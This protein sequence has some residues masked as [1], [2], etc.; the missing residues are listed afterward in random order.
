MAFVTRPIAFEYLDGGG[1]SRAIGAEETE[2]LTVS[3]IEGDA[4]DP[5]N[6]AVGLA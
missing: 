5:L 1:L 3:N 4:M 2:N 6:V